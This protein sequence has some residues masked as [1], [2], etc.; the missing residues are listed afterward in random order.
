MK[1]YEDWMKRAKSAYLYAITL[2]DEDVYYKD[3]CYQ[4]QQATEKAI[5]GLLIYY[6]IEPEYT[7]DIGKLLK[8]LRKHTYIPDNIMKTKHLTQY[9]I[10]TRYPGAHYVVTEEM[11][12]EAIEIAKNCLDWVEKK[13]IK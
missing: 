3:K 9:A 12:A 11:F 4:A 6:G 7:H 8:V 1:I 2:T 10:V 5:K 13:I